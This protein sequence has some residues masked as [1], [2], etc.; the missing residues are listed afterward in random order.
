[1][2][3]IVAVAKALY[4]V[5]DWADHSLPRETARVVSWGV[6]YVLDDLITHLREYKPTELLELTQLVPPL[7]GRL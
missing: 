2:P 5:R 7:K 6:F 1:M 3:S 4:E